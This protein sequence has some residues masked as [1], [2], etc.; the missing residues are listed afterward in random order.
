MHR[1]KVGYGHPEGSFFRE[2]DH[3]DALSTDELRAHVVEAAAVVAEADRAKWEAMIAEEKAK[4]KDISL[5]NKEPW[6]E[7]VNFDDLLYT[8]DFR[9]A[10][11][12]RGFRESEYVAKVA[13]HGWANAFDR[14]GPHGS[15]WGEKSED[16]LAIQAALRK[17]LGVE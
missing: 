9:D 3:P 14:S 4:G 12:V 16:T 10:M 17:R 2:F 7:H 15:R 6:Y 8:N 11:L 1:Y 5:L 13:L